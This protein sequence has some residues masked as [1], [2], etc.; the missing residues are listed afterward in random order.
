MLSVVPSI[1]SLRYTAAPS[2]A[3]VWIRLLL[4]TIKRRHLKEKLE[5]DLACEDLMTQS[6]KQIGLEVM[7][8][9]HIY[10]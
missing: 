4:L 5:K 10:F 6:A 3:G 8:S 1:N 9:S 2:C 7:G